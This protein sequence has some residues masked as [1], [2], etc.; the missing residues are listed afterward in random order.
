MGSPKV[1]SSKNSFQ[2][3]K[4]QLVLEIK[5]Y[6]IFCLAYMGLFIMAGIQII[7]ESCSQCFRYFLSFIPNLKK[8][9]VKHSAK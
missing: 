4:Q 3:R 6:I 5:F 7:E 8:T 2:V 1:G 9:N